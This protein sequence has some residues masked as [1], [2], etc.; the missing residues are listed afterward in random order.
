MRTACVKRKAAMPNME[1]SI[2][3]ISAGITKNDG[4]IWMAKIDLDY[5]YGHAKLSQEAA[6]HCVFSIIEN[7]STGHY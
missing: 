1:E 5:A 7:D 2:N 3:K 4:E 6:R